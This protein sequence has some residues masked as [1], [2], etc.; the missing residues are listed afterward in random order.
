LKTPHHYPTPWGRA[1]HPAL[2]SWFSAVPLSPIPPPAAPPAIES[3]PRTAQQMEIDRQDHDS[4]RKHPETKDRQER[5]QPAKNQANSEQYPFEFGSG[6]PNRAASKADA[7]TCRP[8]VWHLPE[9]SL[10]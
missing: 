3:P 6:Q 9:K 7:V 5:E 10:P 1:Y 8:G 2:F 4:Q